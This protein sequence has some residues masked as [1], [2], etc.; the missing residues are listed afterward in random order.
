MEPGDEICVA[1]DG[2]ERCA[3]ISAEVKFCRNRTA[4]HPASTQ[5]LGMP[6]KGHAF[7]GGAGRKN[8]S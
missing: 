6:E 4:F 8:I 7:S 5:R 2:S 3:T 1:I